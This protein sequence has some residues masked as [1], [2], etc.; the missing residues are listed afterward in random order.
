MFLVTE[1]NKDKKVNEMRESFRCYAILDL[2]NNQDIEKYMDCV[3]LN[4]KGAPWD[5]FSFLRYHNDSKV[6]WVTEQV[7]ISETEALE[8]MIIT[9]KIFDE[10]HTKVTLLH[11]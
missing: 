11:L 8:P 2:L 3:F 6:L 7:K 9:Q 5:V 4:A 1:T 10:E